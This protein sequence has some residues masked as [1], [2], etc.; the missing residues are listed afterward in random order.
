MNSPGIC[1]ENNMI[2]LLNSFELNEIVWTYYKW[3]FI[4]K[5]ID[6]LTILF[7]SH[8]DIDHKQVWYKI[9]LTAI[10]I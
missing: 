4:I 6:T 8:C 10:V 9:N 5:S 3:K 7:Q 1:I 2:F